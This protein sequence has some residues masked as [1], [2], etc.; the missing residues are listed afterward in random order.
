MSYLDELR[1]EIPNHPPTDECPDQECVI[2]GM[3]DCPYGGPL[4]YH[5]DGC[6]DCLSEDKEPT[7]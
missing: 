7:P 6:P 4:H 1:A 2:C 3:R 5:H